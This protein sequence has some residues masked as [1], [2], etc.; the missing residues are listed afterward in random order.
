MSA[1][2]DP[3]AIRGPLLAGIGQ[4]ATIA[5]TQRAREMRA[6]GRDVIALSNGQPDLPPPENIRRAAIAA[7]E[8][9]E[10]KYPPVPGIPELREAVRRKFRR[11]NGLDYRVEQTIVSTGGKQVLANALL[12]T[13]HP[14]DEVVIPAPYFV[15][16]S[17]LVEMAAGRAVIVPTSAEHGF[18]LQPADLDAAITPRTRWVM[19]NSPCN[20]SGAAYSWAEM[21]ALT[22]VLLAHPHVLVLADDI[23]EHLTYGDFVFV[24]PAQVEPRLM[25]RT[26]TMNGVSKAYAMTGWRIGYAAGPEKLIRT[27]NLMQSQMTSGANIIAQ[28]ASVEALDGPQDFVVQA[29]RIFQDRRDLVVSMLNQAHGLHCP[30]P[31]G[32]FYVFPRCDALIGRRA[33]SGRVIA[34][35]AAF[36]EELLEIEG[37]AVVQGSAFGQGPNF[38]ISYA[39]ATAQLEEAC[40]R[41]QRFCATLA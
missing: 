21:K 33:P 14:G 16:Y 40:M 30:T 1:S 38:R 19:F 25:D 4:S 7:I 41:I 17:Q 12:G 5:M 37:V 23:Y 8:R 22:D 36:A 11:E 31:E 10:S 29:R 39:A 2:S 20:P 15:S 9:G 34:D 26:L 28:W 35:D 32:A 3:A 6:A 27:M 13:L 18:K 24:T